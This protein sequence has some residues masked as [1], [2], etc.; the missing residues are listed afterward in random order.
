VYDIYCSGGRGYVLTGSEILEVDLESGEVVG[1]ALL[2]G[3]PATRLACGDG[4]VSA[5]VEAT[6]DV[7][8]GRVLAVRSSEVR[9]EARSIAEVAR[10]YPRIRRGWRG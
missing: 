4:M 7:G 6:V 1:A 8:G 9:V 3:V 10:S 2:P 5:I